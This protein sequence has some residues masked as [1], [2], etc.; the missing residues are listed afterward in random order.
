MGLPERKKSK[1]R[2]E[3]QEDINLHLS[4][5]S[6]VWISSSGTG[7]SLPVMDS[8]YI[9]NCLA[10]IKNDSHFAIGKGHFVFLMEMELLYREKE[11]NKIKN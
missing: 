9:K 10:K 1:Y 5:R 6:I 2:M 7:Y 8:N 3:T 4:R 11:L